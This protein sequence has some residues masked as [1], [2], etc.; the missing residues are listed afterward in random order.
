MKIYI[1]TNDYMLE[2]LDFVSNCRDAAAN[3][4]NVWR[5]GRFFCIKCRMIFVDFGKNRKSVSYFTLDTVP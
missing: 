2:E 5:Q 3:M 4:R 1:I